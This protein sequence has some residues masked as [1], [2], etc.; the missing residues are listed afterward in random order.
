MSQLAALQQRFQRHVL[1]SPDATPDGLRDDVRGHL[2]VYV[3]AY[4]GRLREALADNY[5]VLYRALGD[6]AFRELAATYLAAHPSPH[7]SIRWFGDRLDAF[8]VQH[9]D[10]IPHPALRDIARMDWAM[11]GAFDAADA[12]PLAAGD[13][14]GI[15]PE[16]WPGL[17]FTPC[18]SFRLLAL[19]WAI[20]ALWHALSEDENAQTEAPQ[21]HRHQMI[22]WRRELECRWRTV[23][24]IEA[25][26]LRIVLDGGSFADICATL[27]NQG[28]GD[29]ATTAAR[30]LATW[31]NDGIL[32]ARR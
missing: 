17:R 8:I 7:R 27:Q 23:T 13:L 32:A 24:G 6:D 30:L 11:R 19:D 25:A 18:P 15:A 31:L 10:V 5:P 16:H 21:A 12:T 14:A 2:E 1:S 4:W 22:V 29:A 3:N 9:P 28:D 20:E 26:A